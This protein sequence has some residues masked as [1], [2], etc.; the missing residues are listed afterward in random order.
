MRRRQFIILVGVWRNGSNGDRALM[1]WPGTE[2]GPPIY[3]GAWRSPKWITY[4]ARQCDGWIASG[5]YSSWPDIETGI[6]LFREAGGKRAILANVP[7]DVIAKQLPNLESA[8]GISLVCSPEEARQ[9]LSRLER[10]GFD[11]VLVISPID[12][13]QQLEVL[14]GTLA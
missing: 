5:L 7:L 9:R 3:L 8:R 10:L 1:P 12:Q 6:R 4:A 11:D 13:P 2:G 14:A